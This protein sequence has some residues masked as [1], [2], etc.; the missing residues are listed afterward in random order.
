MPAARSPR[1]V[2]PTALL[3]AADAVRREALWVP[4]LT[5]FDASGR[6]DRVRT[7]GQVRA[8]RSSLRGYLLAGSTGAGWRVSDRQFGQLL[9]AV[10]E[11]GVFE[12]TDM[13]LAGCL[14]PTTDEV[15]A[16]ARAAESA[17]R[18]HPGYVGVT[19][20]PPVGATSQDEILRHYHAV[21]DAIGS[22]VAV[23]QLPQVTHCEVEPETMRALAAT[24]RVHMFKDT[25]GNDRVADSGVLGPEVWTLRGAEGAYYE[26]LKP[27]G[28]YD[29]WLLSTANGFAA[30]YRSIIALVQAGEHDAAQALSARVARAVDAIFA[31]GTRMHIG[32]VFSNANRAIDQVQAYGTRCLDVPMPYRVDMTQVPRDFVAQT[33]D[34]VLR[35]SLARDRG[36]L[37]EQS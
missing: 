20:C 26:A 11:G 1:P 12:A 18:S 34:I 30:N 37:D 24:G 31:L 16:R 13:V 14:R 19:V 32:N 28:H 8:L 25:S 23:Y 2:R 6:I 29:G 7:G 9:D 22:P 5:H 33:Y 4:L 17:L 15:V 3:A 10:A 35:E 21:F 27:R 36:Y